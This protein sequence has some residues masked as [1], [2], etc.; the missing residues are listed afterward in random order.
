MRVSWTPVFLSIVSLLVLTLAS[1]RV[2]ASDSARADDLVPQRVRDQVATDGRARVIVEVRLAPSPF[3][4][5]GELPTLAHIV[6]QRAN[7]AFAQSQVLSRLQG[8]SHTVRHRFQTAPY[9]ALEVESDAL[10]QLE[11][12]AFYIQ[13]VVEDT[14]NEPLL[15]QSVPIVEGNQAWAAG[16]DGTGSVIAILDTGVDKTHPFLAGKVIEEACFSST[17]EG[18]T[19][20]VCPNGQSQQF[21]PGS[22]VNCPLSVATCWHG[23]HVAGIAAGNGAGAGVA[24]SGVAKGAKLMAV[25]VFSQGGFA[26]CGPSAPCAYAWLSDILAGLERVYSLRNQHNFSSVNLSVGSGQYVG[27]CDND[28]AKPFIDNLRSVGI[29]TV[30]AAGNGAATGAVSTPACVSSAV[31]VGSTSKGDNLSGFSNVGPVL[32]LLAPGEGI[33]SSYPGSAWQ[34]ASGT[35]MATPHVSGTWAILKQAA[36]GSSVSALLTALQQTGVLIADERLPNGPK[37]RIRIAAALSTLPHTAPPSYGRNFQDFNG[38]GKADILWR[39]TS[40]SVSVWLLNGLSLVGTRSYEGVSNEWSVVGVGDFNGDGKADILWRHTSGSVSVWLLDGVGVIGTR[41]YDGIPNEWT[42][43]GVGDFNGDG[44][45]DILWR[46]SSG[47]VAVWLLNG[48]N[49]T[50]SGLPGSASADWTIAGVGDFN[51]DGKADILWR[52]TS[53]TVAV[54]LLNGTNLISSG[55]PGSLSTDWTIGGVG[56]FNGD[57]KAD[58]L[59][60]HTSGTIAV[61]LLNGVSVVA[62]GTLAGLSTEWTVEGVGDFNGDGKADVLWRHSSGTVAEWLFNGLSVIGSGE[63]GAPSLDWQIQ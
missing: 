5:E 34:T 46:H 12:S 24:Y 60:R 27:N 49:V 39:H 52:H 35:S 41:V 4:P 40:G 42:V 17:V 1:E 14:L 28:P 20:S 54:W 26:T 47:T 56:D 29:A 31:S 21:G 58:I 37:P 51:G 19:T 55:L 9:L 13:R 32:S 25:Q 36:P 45:A 62:S 33:L 8:L 59:W 43:A 7:L 57:H 48:L 53:G 50:S 44:K 6:A 2:V 3:R 15:P 23:T 11:A 30:A 22:G 61:W 38:D 63:L 18:K 16:F 10:R